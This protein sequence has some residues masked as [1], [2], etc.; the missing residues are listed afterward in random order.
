MQGVEQLRK[1]GVG[2]GGVGDRGLGRGGP[3]RTLD[4]DS[5][6]VLSCDLSCDRLAL[7]FSEAGVLPLV[8]KGHSFGDPGARASKVRRDAS[9]RSL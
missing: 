5:G 1:L 9:L 3:S 4:D 8:S 7:P 6:G 2:D